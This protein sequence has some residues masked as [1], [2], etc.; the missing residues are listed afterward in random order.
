MRRS[1]VV[2]M[3]A[4]LTVACWPMSG[5]ERHENGIWSSADGR[6][7]HFRLPKEDIG[8]DYVERL[9]VFLVNLR[10]KDAEIEAQD[11]YIGDGDVAIPLQAHQSK[12]IFMQGD[13]QLKSGDRFEKGSKIKLKKGFKTA[14]ELKPGEIYVILPGVTFERP[15]D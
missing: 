3:I 12:G 7:I 5:A 4:I 2:L 13:I 9:P 14:K 11:L 10:T 8:I 1:Y 6:V 15:K